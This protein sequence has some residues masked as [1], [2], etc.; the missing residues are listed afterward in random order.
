MLSLV[1]GRLLPLLVKIGNIN[2]QF[3][4]ISIKGEKEVLSKQ[5]THFKLKSKGNIP[6]AHIKELVRDLRVIEIIR[7]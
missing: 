4:I 3:I 1:F 2:E 6:L 5:Y 7:W